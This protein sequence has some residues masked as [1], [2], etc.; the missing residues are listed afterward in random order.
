MFAKYLVTLSLYSDVQ[1]AAELH[2]E[3]RGWNAGWQSVANEG[4]ITI[5]IM[6]PSGTS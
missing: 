4:S 1:P 6:F 5:T 2:S 3:R